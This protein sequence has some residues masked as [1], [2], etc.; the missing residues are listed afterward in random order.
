M[1][2]ELL[3]R[4]EESLPDFTASLDA[5]RHG[6]QPE[7][8]GAKLGWD[9][10]D[11]SLGAARVLRKLGRFDEASAELKH[12][13]EVWHEL[14]AQH[15]S[16]GAL[17]IEHGFADM[18]RGDVSAAREQA[19]RA[20]TSLPAWPAYDFARRELAALEEKIA[21]QRGGPVRPED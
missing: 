2:Y 7:L 5:Y 21:R 19:A 18:A 14:P 17:A 1:Q 11:L 8:F 16:R 12:A 20:R 3:G 13:E 4:V 9:G 6:Q 15:P 10:G